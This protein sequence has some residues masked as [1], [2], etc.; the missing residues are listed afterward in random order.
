MDAFDALKA[1][2][3]Q[4]LKS[5]PTQRRRQSSSPKG[6]FTVS[7]YLDNQ[8]AFYHPEVEANQENEV[9]NAVQL[10]LP[11]TQEEPAQLVLP[12]ASIEQNDLLSER[13]KPANKTQPIQKQD[14]MRDKCWDKPHLRPIRENAYRILGLPADAD[15]PTI[16]KRVDELKL[17][18]KLGKALKTDWDLD[19]VW[20]VE[21]TEATIQEALW[22]LSDP[23]LRLREKLFWFTGKHTGAVS[24]YQDTDEWR[25]EFV[26]GALSNPKLGHDVAIYLLM[27][28]ASV[29]LNYCLEAWQSTLV[30]WRLV[31]ADDYFWNSLKAQEDQ[32]QFLRSATENDIDQLRIS[33]LLQVTEGFVSQAQQ[34][35][36]DKDDAAVEAILAVIDG[37]D[38]AEYVDEQIEAAIFG[39]MKIDLE[40]LYDDVLAENYRQDAMNKLKK[41]FLPLYERLSKLLKPESRLRPQIQETVIQ[42]FY[43]ILTLWTWSGDEPDFLYLR[44]EAKRIAPPDSLVL[45]RVEL[46]VKGYRNE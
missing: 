1:I 31:A 6:A 14:S 29:E 34:A 33:C 15:F 19:W 45:P 43:R 35:L 2:R 20:P 18:A 4:G 22:R 38:L 9:A 40:K 44:R 27:Q 42:C 37:A 11:V 36:I 24:A 16:Q 26:V 7:Q 5:A 12:I 25:T 10:E 3:Y 17:Q 23:A 32:G 28:T 39:F 8:N 30:L 41:E 13:L 46:L 21:R